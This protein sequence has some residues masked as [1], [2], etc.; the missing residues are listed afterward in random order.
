MYVYL[1]TYI[2]LISSLGDNM[3]N[4]ACISADVAI[5]QLQDVDRNTI[6][7]F[8]RKTYYTSSQLFVSS[9]PLVKKSTKSSIN[10]IRERNYEI[11]GSA[12]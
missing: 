11:K 4:L 5:G 9:N 8:D 6:G 7:N 2:F 1:H 3:Y 10:I 12:R